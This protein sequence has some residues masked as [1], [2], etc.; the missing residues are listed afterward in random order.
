[1]FT[2]N[3][4]GRADVW[5]RFEQEFE[6][7][8]DELSTDPKQK[9]KLEFFERIKIQNA[10]SAPGSIQDSIEHLARTCA[11]KKL[12]RVYGAFVPLVEALKDYTAVIDTMGTNL[13]SSPRGFQMLS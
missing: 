2:V 12:R 6:R 9:K 1:M 8:C 7:F 10:M 3:Y 13:F 4:L 5:L 11:D